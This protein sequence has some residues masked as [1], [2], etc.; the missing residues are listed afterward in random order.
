MMLA[1][2]SC[3]VHNRVAVINI[4]LDVYKIRCSVFGLVL[5]RSNVLGICG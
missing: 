4:T 5:G 1:A 3:V 2:E